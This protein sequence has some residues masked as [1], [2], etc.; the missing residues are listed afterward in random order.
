MCHRRE[1]QIRKLFHDLSKLASI[2]E[3]WMD[4]GISTGEKHPR[5]GFIYCPKMP[6]YEET[7]EWLG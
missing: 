3:G 2:P 4:A 6:Q 5:S 7:N 1:N